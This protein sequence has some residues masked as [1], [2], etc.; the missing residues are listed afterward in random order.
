MGQQELYRAIFHLKDIIMQS[1]I[2]LPES[3]AVKPDRVINNS[4]DLPNG[5]YIRNPFPDKQLL[6]VE[7]ALHAIESIAGM[8]KIDRRYRTIKSGE[9]KRGR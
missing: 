8:I 6:T 9:V 4:S 5:A 3:A 7:E 1:N 2:K